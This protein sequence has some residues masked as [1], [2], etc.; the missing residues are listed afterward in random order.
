MHNY[1][2]DVILVISAFS[3]DSEI[4]GPAFLELTEAEIKE[5]VKPLAVKKLFTCR[6]LLVNQLLW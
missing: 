2:L 1:T 5:M 3:K 4:D 6:N